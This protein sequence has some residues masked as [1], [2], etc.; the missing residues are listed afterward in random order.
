[1]ES[2]IKFYGTFDGADENVAFEFLLDLDH[3]SKAHNLKDENILTCFPTLLRGNAKKW[4]NFSNFDKSSLDS[5]K[6]AFRKRFVDTYKYSTATLFNQKQRV[7]E[8]VLDYITCM[9]ALAARLNTPPSQVFESIMNGFLPEIKEKVIMND[10]RTLEDLE[11]AAVLSELAASHP[12]F[13]Q[14]S[15]TDHSTL[16]VENL[17]QAFSELI[18]TQTKTIKNIQNQGFT[19]RQGQFR[20]T[21]SKSSSKT[22]YLQ[23]CY[24]C[25]KKHSRSKCKYKNAT[26]NNCGI[27]G[28]ISPVC[29]RYKNPSLTP[30]SLKSLR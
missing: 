29:R 9:K 7:G 13:R 15:G 14:S 3:Y 18:K 8:K 16:D 30:P 1:M 11:D 26:C 12:A 25:G 10:P 6:T 19:Q 27:Q 22:Q 4:Y 20:H 24:S 28:H 21:K 2:F 23:T 5:V 17:V